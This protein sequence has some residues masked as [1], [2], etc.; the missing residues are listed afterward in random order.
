MKQGIAN[1]KALS[2]KARLRIVGLTA[3]IVAVMVFAW[4]YYGDKSEPAMAKKIEQSAADRGKPPLAFTE[5][6]GQWD[7]RAKFMARQ[8]GMVAWFEQDAITL[9]LAGHG[10]DK[11][12]QG[13]VTRLTFKDASGTVRLE[14]ENR[15]AAATNYFVGNDRKRWQ[16]NVAGYEQILYTGLYAGVDLVPECAE[17]GRASRA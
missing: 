9:Q 5:N 16:S 2:A 15:Q 3:I 13:V 7:S 6:Q 8:G 12:P 10:A 11:G 1:R 17:P 4:R 14:G